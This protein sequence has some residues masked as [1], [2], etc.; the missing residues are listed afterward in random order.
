MRLFYLAN[1][2]TRDATC[3]G[4]P[5]STTLSDGRS[6]PNCRADGQ[7]WLDRF[8]VL[9]NN[10]D[11]PI[12]LPGLQRVLAPFQTALPQVRVILFY[13]DQDETVKEDY[14]RSD[15]VNVARVLQRLLPQ[16]LGNHV[17]VTIVRLEGNPAD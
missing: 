12:L 16:R 11:A 10:L 4:K 9:E 13:T 5:S 1:V 14:R 2:G 3:N 6:V 8:V 7:Q 15:T 17:Q